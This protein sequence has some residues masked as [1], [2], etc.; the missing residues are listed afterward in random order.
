MTTHGEVSDYVGRRKFW[1]AESETAR[2]PR[3]AAQA[4]YNWLVVSN[5]GYHNKAP[6]GK[7]SDGSFS[8]ARRRNGVEGTGRTYM[9]K[10]CRAGGSKAVGK[11]RHDS[12]AD[13]ACRPYR[14]FDRE[15]G[16]L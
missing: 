15:A 11:L 2:R 12:G 1:E 16:E 14:L 3:Q 4:E 10:G 8:Y 9:C 5:D 7:E 6:H 13:C